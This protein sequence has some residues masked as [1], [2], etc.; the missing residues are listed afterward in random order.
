MLVT[1]FPAFGNDLFIVD[2]IQIRG[3]KQISPGMVFN[4][5]PVTIGDTM[6]EN[7]IRRAVRALFKTG[8]FSDVRLERD[9][10]VL[11][12]IV[13]ERPTIALITFDGNRAIKTEDLEDGLADAGFS[14][15]EV[16]N[17]GKLDKVIQELRR[18]YYA[19]GKYGAQVDYEI[20]PIGD[21]AIEIAF[22]IVEGEAAKIKQIKIVGNTVYSDEELLNVFKLKTGN[23]LSWFRKDDQYSK[24]KLSGDL[25]TLRSWY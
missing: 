8:F 20:S 13:E 18:Q 10:D 12:V 2:D 16:F 6:D 7:R 9:G 24:Q 11:V 22:L 4:Y 5:L 3:L 1:N 17:Q 21:D 23:W 15:G 25:E 19:N 14:E